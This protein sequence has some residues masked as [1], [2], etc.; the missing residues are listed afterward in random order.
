MF[1]VRVF[2]PNAPSNKEKTLENLYKTHEK[3]KNR[4]YLQRVLQ[5]EKAI[6]TPLV[7]STNG[8]MAPQAV[9]FH[10]R[11]S[12]LISQKTGEKYND[13]ISCMRT[14]VNFAM[15]R[16]VPMSVR[17][18]RG[19]PSRVPVTPISCLSFNLIPGMEDYDGF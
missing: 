13:V 12:T 8:G 14:K 7:Y 11:L 5:T 19:K 1:D 4:N 9:N 10:K 16:S 6:F 3:E 18:V 2:H 17:G 15:L